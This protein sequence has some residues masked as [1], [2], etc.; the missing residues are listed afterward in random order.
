M[1]LWPS[2]S[3]VQDGL[4]DGDLGRKR[5]ASDKYWSKHRPRGRGIDEYFVAD[6][7]VVFRPHNGGFRS[8]SH[9]PICSAGSNHLEA[10]VGN[11]H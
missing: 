8:G 3:Q 2:A 4:E 1:F 7:K 11:V 5:D 6:V 10:A 9:L